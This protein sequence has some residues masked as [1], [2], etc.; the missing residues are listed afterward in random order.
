MM[1]FVYVFIGGGIGAICRY[2]IS[3]WLGKSETQIMPWPTL[4]S[5]V[6]AC[7]IAGL[8]I[9]WL[10]KSAYYTEGRLWLVT[11]FCGGFSTFS[12]FG[13]ETIFMIQRG[14]MMPALMYVVLSLASC[15]LAVIAGLKISG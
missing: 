2:G 1:G 5:N 8:L 4:V 10:P 9:A 14:Q 15:L 7:F 13:V 11:G 3:L 12:T 6:L